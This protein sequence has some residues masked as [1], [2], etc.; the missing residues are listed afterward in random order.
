MTRISHQTDAVDIDL[1]VPLKTVCFIIFKA[2]EFHAKDAVTDPDS[3]SNPAD[4]R[5]AAVLEDHPDDPVFEELVSLI[6]NLSIDEQIDLVALMW[7]GRDDYSV[8]DWESVR[9]DAAAAHNDRT[10]RYLCGDPL[11]ADCLSDGLSLLDYSCAK[12][13]LEH[14]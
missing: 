8:A 9:A 14:L 7:L 11:L 6:S 12:F 1:S 3:S 4:D 2:R 13:E 10:A 5:G